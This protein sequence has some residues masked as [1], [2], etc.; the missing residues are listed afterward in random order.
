MLLLENAV[1]QSVTITPGATNTIQTSNSTNYIDLKKTGTNTFAGFRFLQNQSVRGGL[2][3]NDEQN[4]INL[5][6]ASNSQGL[7]WNNT[8]QRVGIGVNAPDARLHILTNSTGTVPHLLVQ[9]NNNSDGA[10]INFENFGIERTWTLYGKNSS[11]TIPSDNV[12]NIYHSSFGNIAQFTGDG[13]T[14]LN[15]FTQLGAD[16]PKIKVKK[17]TGILDN[18]AST[19]IETAFTDFSKIV[20]FTGYILRSSIPQLAINPNEEDNDFHYVL[21]LLGNAQNIDIFF[22]QVPPALRGQTYT[23]YITFEE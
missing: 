6:N 5:S 20:S 17:F 4:V 14:Q 8:S 7:I 12:L 9:E 3:Y 21:R 10:R 18:D 22:S 15:G 11:S 2:F 16:A 1:A 23:V 19:S 13:N